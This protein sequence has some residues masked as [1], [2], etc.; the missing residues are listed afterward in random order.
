MINSIVIDIE[1]M[2]V[3]PS[4]LILSIGAFAFDI[5]NI[6]KT[7]NSILEVS[8]D[9]D[10]VEYSPYTFMRLSI[11]STSSCLAVLLAKIHSSGGSLRGKMLMKL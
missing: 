5:A 6:E 7:R 2:D 8:Q 4:A 1:T 11:R 10:V 9:L 3:R